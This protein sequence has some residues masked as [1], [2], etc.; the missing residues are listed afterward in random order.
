MLFE[1]FKSNSTLNLNY[2]KNNLKVFYLPNL[3]ISP[4]PQITDSRKY[5]VSIVSSGLRHVISK[6]ASAEVNRG[7]RKILY[8]PTLL[9]FK[10]EFAAG[11]GCKFDP[12]SI[13]VILDPAD[14][15]MN[16]TLP[17]LAEEGGSNSTT[18]K[19]SLHYHKLFT[20]SKSVDF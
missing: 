17:D 19:G 14:S 2:K 13:E 1:H 16:T 8:R 6:M 18:E 7:K 4:F 20:F 3:E 5:P 10:I 15:W 11:D 9:D 12:S